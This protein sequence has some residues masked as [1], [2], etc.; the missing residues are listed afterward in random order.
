MDEWKG[1]I[2]LQIKTKAKEKPFK[3]IG[4]DKCEEQKCER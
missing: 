4:C 3:Q 2:F 1:F